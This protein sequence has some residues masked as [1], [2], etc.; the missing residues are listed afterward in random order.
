MNNNIFF[1][2]I[3]KISVKNICQELK[4]KNISKKTIFLKDIKPLEEASK[5][6]LT[7]LHSSKYLELIPKT[8]S[9]FIIT[10]S[11]FK[12]YISKKNLFVVDNILLSVAKITE[13]FYPDSLNEKFVS[14]EKTKN[15]YL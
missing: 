10:S 2:K 11:K 4:I 13:L 9:E 1:N 6:D 12:K 8:K 7:F 5:N 15:N 14:D 3:N